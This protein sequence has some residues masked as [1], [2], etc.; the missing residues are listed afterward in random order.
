MARPPSGFFLM[1]SHLSVCFPVYTI[2]QKML[3]PGGNALL[4][5]AMRMVENAVIKNPKR[6]DIPLREWYVQVPN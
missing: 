2:S 3:S 5:L 6:F 1:K 4:R